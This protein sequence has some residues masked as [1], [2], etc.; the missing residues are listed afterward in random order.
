M[1]REGIRKWDDAH[2]MEKEKEKEK[3]AVVRVL[4]GA[5]I[6]TMD[7]ELRVFRDGGIVVEHDRIKA[8]GHSSHILAHFS[9]LADHILDLTGHI[10]LPGSSLR[11]S[12][13]PPF[14]LHN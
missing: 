5:V 6:I 7:E 9:H 13:I 3:K 14:I 10:L 1:R 12:S 8:I 2:A 11:F 4:H